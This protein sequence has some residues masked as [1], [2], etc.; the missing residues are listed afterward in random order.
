ME[1]QHHAMKKFLSLFITL[2]AVSCASGKHYSMEDSVA[3]TSMSMD[4]AAKKRKII[5]SA[6]I[7]LES[8]NSE[9]LVKK[10]T[11][12]AKS[13]NG[14]VLYSGNERISIRVESRS[15]KEAFAKIKSFDKLISWSM[16]ARDVTEQFTDQEIRLENKLKARERYLELLK[17]AENVK[18]ALE[19]E[20]ELERLN[21][22]IELYKGKIQKLSHLTE[23]STIDIYIRK[24]TT[25][26]PLGWVF[27]SIK[28]AVTWLFVI[29]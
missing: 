19:V 4:E 15:L 26:G 25:L 28:K 10:A 6:S 2:L 14:Y 22:E 12:L 7:T 27:W 13:Y 16:S 3:T 11:E 17:K 21:G 29:E 1:Y 24:K 18:T 20:K 23:F 8:T 5:Y 9:N